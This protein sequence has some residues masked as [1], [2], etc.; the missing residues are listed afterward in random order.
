MAEI[1]RTGVIEGRAGW[2]SGDHRREKIKLWFG[3]KLNDVIHN[4][5]DW[6]RYVESSEPFTTL[7]EQAWRL[8]QIASAARKQKP[9]FQFATTPI[10]NL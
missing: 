6:T 1:L 2:F 9:K 4:G 5:E 7:S 10:D 8:E 3:E